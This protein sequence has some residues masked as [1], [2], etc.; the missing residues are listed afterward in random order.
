[1]ERK[2]KNPTN[3]N[4]SIINPPLP[5]PSPRRPL[6]RHTPRSGFPLSVA[7]RRQRQRQFLL[8][9][10][11]GVESR[12]VDPGDGFGVCGAEGRVGGGEARGEGESGEADL[13]WGGEVEKWIVFGGWRVCILGEDCLCM[14]CIALLLERFRSWKK[15]KDVNVVTSGMRC[16]SKQGDALHWKRGRYHEGLWKR[17]FVEILR[18]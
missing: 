7:V 17:K 15:K 9:Y 11:A 4:H 18:P 13:R 14:G 1:M 3:D 2:K 16:M 10:H 6:I 12:A 5:F 8:C